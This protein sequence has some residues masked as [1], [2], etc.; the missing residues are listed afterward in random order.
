[1]F[2]P[3]E[4]ISISRAWR[5]DSQWLTRGFQGLLL[6][7]GIGLP[8]AFA[9]EAALRYLAPGYAILALVAVLYFGFSLVHFL[10]RKPTVRFD[11]VVDEGIV[12][13]E[14]WT[15]RENRG[16]LEGLIGRIT[17]LQKRI[18][19]LIPYPVQMSYQLFHMRSFRITILR[20]LTFTAILYG[21]CLLLANWYQ[22]PQLWYFLMLPWLA[23][24]GK[25]AFDRFRLRAQPR[26]F[27]TAVR[28]YEEER[29][30]EAGGLLNALTAEEPD[31]MPGLV[32]LAQVCTLK[33][34]F[35]SAYRACERIEGHAPDLAEAL[36]D[37][38][39][40]IER[41]QERMDMD[42]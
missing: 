24:V 38:I 12:R 4:C 27:R 42:V 2:I 31:Y 20:A 36:R 23:Y 21:P 33:G 37:E 10:R 26:L 15:S 25:Y 7:V 8:L 18:D 29:L 11:A 16:D 30:S 39:L 40:S 14:C 17:S 35:D 34:E 3:I 32:L 9:S 22:L 6:A 41:L 1:M 28:A 13:I 5:F 19:D